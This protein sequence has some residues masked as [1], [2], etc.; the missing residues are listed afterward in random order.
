MNSRRPKISLGSVLFLHN[1]LNGPKSQPST[2]I[3]ATNKSPPT[4]APITCTESAPGHEPGSKRFD[5]I[6][7]VGVGCITASAVYGGNELANYLCARRDFNTNPL[8]APETCPRAGA[9]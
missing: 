6:V 9:S 2:A 5:G 1:H 3:A 8:T 7:G 4:S